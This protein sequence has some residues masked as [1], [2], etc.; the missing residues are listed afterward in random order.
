M[1]S[2][3]KINLAEEAPNHP[4]VNGCI[5]F[6]MPKPLS[7]SKGKSTSTKP[8][9]DVKELYPEEVAK[10]PPEESWQG[11]F[12][13]ALVQTWSD[14]S[15]QIVS[16]AFTASPS[17]NLKFNFLKQ[18]FVTIF[19]RHAEAQAGQPDRLLLG[20]SGP[21]RFYVKAVCSACWNV[22]FWKFL[23]GANDTVQIIDLLGS[24]TSK[25][26]LSCIGIIT[27][28]MM[29]RIAPGHIHR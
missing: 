8:V 25:F 24:R 2:L 20:L 12:S 3:G 5:L 21:C 14:T 16:F 10:L 18:N 9:D 6:G 1:A 22:C 15:C 17:C 23:E 11:H 29:M 7:I 4:F 13:G 26:A 28:A 27:A 19:Y